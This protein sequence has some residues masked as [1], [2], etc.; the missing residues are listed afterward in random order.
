MY[1]QSLFTFLAAISFTA[2]AAHPG[3]AALE[4]QPRA[5]P[6]PDC[7]AN[8]GHALCCQGTF[9]GDLPVIVALAGLASFKLNPNDINCIGSKFIL[10]TLG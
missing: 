9:A 8:G 1:L 4:L 5:N 3:P 7:S 2:A 6:I 10:R